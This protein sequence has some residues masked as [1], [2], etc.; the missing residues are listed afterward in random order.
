MSPTQ[1]NKATLKDVGERK[2]E[3]FTGWALWSPVVKGLQKKV[4]PSQRLT[5]AW[6][7]RIGHVHGGALVS[8]TWAALRRKGYRV[9][10]VSVHELRT[11]TPK[12][13]KAIRP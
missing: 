11:A 4:F 8:E 1:P 5:R 13:K 6:A 3:Y 9:V 12:K 7:V 2:L 10:R